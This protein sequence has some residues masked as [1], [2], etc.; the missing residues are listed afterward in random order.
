MHS[1]AHHSKSSTNLPLNWK[2][3]DSVYTGDDLIDAFLKGKEAG[4]NERERILIN[5]LNN[6]II[7][8]ANISEKMF[9]EAAKK[10]IK[11]LSIHL[12]AEDITRYVALF[13]AD[14][15]DFLSDKFRS[16]YIKAQ[17]LK[18]EAETDNFYISFSFM[19]QS[20]ALDENCLIS[21]GFFMK[22]EK[23]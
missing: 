2:K 8:A 10:K 11:L 4:K 21:D 22:Y 13:V 1:V 19:P 16:L 6:N 15:E 12:K 5:Q 18:D 7:H 9:S 23:K 3:S 17:K 14:K 20:P